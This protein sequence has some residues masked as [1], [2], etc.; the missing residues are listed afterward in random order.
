M[1]EGAM[2]GVSEDIVAQRAELIAMIGERAM[3][4]HGPSDE[5][6]D[7]RLSGSDLDCV[8][9]NMDPLWPLRLPPGWRLCQCLRYDLG[10]WYWVLERA[11]EVVA[12]DTIDDPW[13][14]G[15][16]AI[17][18]DSFFDVV[19]REPAE[20][21]KAAYL[22]VKRVRKQN[23]LPEEWERIGRLAR[24]D[25]EEF[26]RTL[27]LLTGHPLSLMLEPA[28]IQGVRPDRW[29][30][31]MVNVL[32]FGRRFGSPARILKT[33]SLAVGRYV[34]RIGHPAGF[35][36]LIVGPDGAG[37]STVAAALP[38]LL[39]GPFKKHAASHW[40]PGIL[41][42]P[43]SLLGRSAPD[44]STPHARSPFGRIPSLLL[45]AYYWADF[46]LGE[47]PFTWLRIRS[48]LIVSERGWWDLV[49]DPRRYRLDVPPRLVRALGT[50]LRKPDLAIVLAAPPETL[51]GRKDEL[52]RAELTRQAD[53]W[54][55]A[56]P[57]SITTL[58]LD[59]SGGVD[60]TFR[61]VREQ[62]LSIL[63]AR[64][65]SRLGSGWLSVPP[66]HPRWWLPRG[67]SSV[68]RAALAV[69]RPSA[70]RARTGWSLARALASVGM[71]RLLPRGSAPPAAVRRILAPHVPV[72][73]TIA[74]SRANHPARYGALLLTPQGVSRAYA[75]VALDDPGVE[76]LEREDRAIE[77]LGGLLTAPLRAP[78][79]LARDRGLLIL[80][81]VSTH[82]SPRPWAM[83]E[84]VAAALGRFFKA[85]SEEVGGE[86]RGP[87]HGDVAPWNL[88]PTD[89]GWVLVDWESAEERTL[90]FHDLCHF[91]VQSHAL[92]GQPSSP[93]VLEGFLDGR[94][95]VAGLIRA[96][97]D[98]SGIPS[99]D[100]PA[101]LRAYLDRTT[102]RMRAR[103]PNESRGLDRRR[104]LAAALGD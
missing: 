23:F 14:L 72:R 86:V 5:G 41:P 48:G 95:W 9:L 52:D 80:E 8:V 98:A 91:L 53:A 87:A 17:K 39:K 99:D 62:A 85:G 68:A 30:V 50:V 104:R 31:E 64:A 103:T 42:R 97:A 83:T 96:Y 101:C 71:F 2:G 43:G 60:A 76:S 11:G 93:E 4:L 7:F 70:S 63:E 27:E 55:R 47:I 65:V 82:A 51:I 90:P 94:G 100:A 46:V 40:R 33:A 12:L 84:E 10:G 16:D 54:T 92:L 1:G 26:R 28:A 81:A 73:G 49:V 6:T 29:V 74:V 88:L 67:P 75:K 21:V 77:S 89:G 34:E 36:I 18:T 3:L 57:P 37:K 56:L 32:R 15:R 19:D 61:R 58:H 38:D 20:A 25:P 59:S 35:T 66:R 102:P 79:V 24:R 44:A 69:Y 45:L 78:R 13:G 22:A